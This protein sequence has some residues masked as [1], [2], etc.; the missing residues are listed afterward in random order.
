MAMQSFLI[1]PAAVRDCRKC[2]SLLVEQLGEHGVD[3]STE[4]LSHLLEAVVANESRGF[5]LLARVDE[6]IVGVAYAATILSAEHTGLVAWLEELYVAPSYRSQ[7]IGSALLAAVVERAH[8]AGVVAVDLEVDGSHS[9]VE[10][11]YR[12]LGFR[13]L[14]RSRWVKE[15]MT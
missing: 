11:L 15:L 6:R 3:A 7:G 10:S 12:R 14:N 4:R 2:A 13:S 5:V 9:R 8:K 1:S